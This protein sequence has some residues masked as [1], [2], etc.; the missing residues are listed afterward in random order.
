[1]RSRT[2]EVLATPARRRIFEI[3]TGRPGCSV[4]ELARAA[5]MFW[6]AA[7]LHIEQLERA[8]LVRTVRVGRARALFA[9]SALHEVEAANAAL[10]SEVACLRVA[11]AVVQHPRLRVWEL[12][13][14]TGMS[15]RAT[16][17]HL[18]RLVAAGLVTSRT[19]R[20][21]REIEAS[22]TL[23]ACLPSESLDL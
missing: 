3:I 9:A 15:E 11:R 16:Y 7:A 6:T 18:R 10:L 17:H 23:L 8:G 12:A 13:S 21:Y 22:P 20:G 14:R 1:M 5:G 4:S 2:E 19:T